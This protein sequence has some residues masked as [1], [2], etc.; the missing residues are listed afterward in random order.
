M[1][2]PEKIAELKSKLLKEKVRLESEIEKLKVV[3]FG[4]D[5]DHG[6]E[7]AEEDEQIDNNQ[8]IIIEF[9]DRINNIDSA[10]RKIADGGYGK[11]ENCGKDISLEL[12]E[13]NPE[14]QLCKDCKA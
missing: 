6:D 9:K 1:I 2:T 14:S 13:I 10:L 4:D 12:L 8:S 11:C 3:D 7:E 5:T